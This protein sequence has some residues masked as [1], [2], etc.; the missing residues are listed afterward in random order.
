MSAGLARAQRRPHLHHTRFF[1]PRQPAFWLYVVLVVL[2]GIVAIAEQ[3]LYRNISPGGWALAWFLLLLYGAPVF[4]LV[5][6]LDLYEREPIP[7]LIASFLWGAVAATA[8]SAIGN[9][10]WGLTVAQARRP[11]VRVAMDGGAHGAVRRGDPEGLRRGA[12]LPDRA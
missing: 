11:G 10:G 9:A 12:D 3:S 1:Q 8:L 6:L 4:L 5:Y 2:T 7:L